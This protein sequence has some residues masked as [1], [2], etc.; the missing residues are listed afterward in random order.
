MSLTLGVVMLMAIIIS[1]TTLPFW[2]IYHLGTQ[3][4]KP[5][6]PDYIIVM[7]GSAVP[8]ST[9][10]MRTY[11]AAKLSENYP[12]AKIIL[13]LPVDS[14][15]LIKADNPLRLMHQEL[16][17]RGVKTQVYYEPK[18]TNTRSQAMNIAKMISSNKAVSIISEPV[19]IY[20]SVR[21]FRKLGFETIN[22]IPTFESDIQSPLSY[23]S[24]SLGGRQIAPDVGENIQLRYQF[25][26]HLQ[27]EIILLREYIAIC[28]YK[29]NAWI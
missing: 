22:G 12:K 4:N 28:Y 16:I 15:L 5:I 17:N 23:N 7:G 18:G 3:D 24:E 27:Y 13:T 14:S 29:L 8:S 10:L 6:E 1:F 2:G 26:N 11:Y 25:W 9:A 21:T 19:H 20:R